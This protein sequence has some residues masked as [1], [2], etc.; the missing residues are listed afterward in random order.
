[1]SLLYRPCLD[2]SPNWT[3]GFYIESRV[4][5]EK[6][7]KYIVCRS[8]GWPR[9]GPRS[10]G[11][12]PPTQPPSKRAVRFPATHPTTQNQK[13]SWLFLQFLKGFAGEGPD[14]TSQSRS[15][16]LQQCSAWRSELGDL[17]LEISALLGAKM[18]IEQSSAT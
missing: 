17:S 4:V 6:S 8:V 14:N 3:L 9:S 10:K 15:P 16:D 12:Y 1:M 13:H 2:S 18:L 11:Q 5:Q 7:L